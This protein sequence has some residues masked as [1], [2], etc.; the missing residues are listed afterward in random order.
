MTDN[1]LSKLKKALQEIDDRRF[2]CIGE[3]T[4]PELT[5]NELN[6]KSSPGEIVDLPPGVEA[7]QFAATQRPVISAQCA[8]NGAQFMA[9]VELKGAEVS[10]WGEVMAFFQGQ[11]RANQAAEGG[12]A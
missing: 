6:R 10:A 12:P 3:Q 1:R 2:N 11:I 7:S 9:R 8:H 4:M 5:E